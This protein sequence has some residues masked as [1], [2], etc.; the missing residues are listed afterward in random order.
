MADTTTST[1]LR[2]FLEEINARRIATW[3]APSTVDPEGQAVLYTAGGRSFVV[4]QYPYGGFDLW[5]D[6]P[7]R[8]DACFAAVRDGIAEPQHALER[9]RLVARLE[10]AG[11]GPEHLDDLVHEAMASVA[12]V[13]NNAGLHAQV[14][15]LAETGD[16]DDVRALLGSA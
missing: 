7:V 1:A 5:L 2:D 12:A 11:I 6:T 13:T 3:G 16:L 4:K 8:T 15:L 10:A 14:D 9:D